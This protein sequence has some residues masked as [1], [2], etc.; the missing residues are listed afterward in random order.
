MQEST[1]VETLNEI[2]RI[3]HGL[4]KILQEKTLFQTF[5]K[6]MEKVL[7]EDS[8]EE[9]KGESTDEDEDQRRYTPRQNIRKV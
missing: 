8:D 2:L 5:E 3:L 6:V 1:I 9:E 7:E 4:E